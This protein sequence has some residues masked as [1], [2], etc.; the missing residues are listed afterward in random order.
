ML[1]NGNLNKNERRNQTLKSGDLKILT[2][3]TNEE[4]PIPEKESGIDGDEAKSVK[5]R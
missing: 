2:N 5:W 1:R 4:H 3:V